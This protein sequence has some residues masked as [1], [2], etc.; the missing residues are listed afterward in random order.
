MNTEN[1]QNWYVLTTRSRHEK[2]CEQLLIKQGFEVFLP[3][4]KVMR[5]WSDRKKIVEIPL[6]SGYIFIR[7][8][9]SKRFQ[10]LN[11]PGIVRFLRYN[12][13]DAT[14]SDTQVKAIDIAIKEIPD[15]LYVIEQNFSEGEEICIKSGPFKGFYGKVINYNNNR[16]IMIS[17]DSIGKSLLIETSKTL[18]EK[19][20]K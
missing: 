5:K 1:N 17:I 2:K 19:I 9:E 20:E 16:K 7:Y 14:I 13:A 4:Q 12:N 11:T 15:K 18:I 10:V 3:L 8:D 6:F